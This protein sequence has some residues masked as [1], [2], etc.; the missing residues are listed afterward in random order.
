MRLKPN[1]GDQIQV[2]QWYFRVVRVLQLILWLP[3]PAWNSARRHGTT[4]R[5]VYRDRKW[6]SVWYEAR[7]P[8]FK[9]RSLPA[10]GYYALAL[11]AAGIYWAGLYSVIRAM[12]IYTS[13]S[14]VVALPE[15]ISSSHY[16]EPQAQRGCEV[17]VILRI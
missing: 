13:F 12:G 8:Q 2:P 7:D 15:C 11:V 5:F 10:F 14:L 16:T 4:H 3:L 1:E 6:H 9:W 17:S